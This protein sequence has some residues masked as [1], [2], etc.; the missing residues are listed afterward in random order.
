MF[1]L[2]FVMLFSCRI[3]REALRIKNSRLALYVVAF[4]CSSTG[5]ENALIARNKTKNN[6]IHAR[7]LNRI[8]D[9]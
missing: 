1:Y 8:K 6:E 4:G 2:V 3:T 5:W 7:L 9:I